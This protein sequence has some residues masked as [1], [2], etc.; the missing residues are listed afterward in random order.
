MA[1]RTF[2]SYK[3]SESTELRDRIV[4]SLGDDAGYY[5]GETSDS[6]DR[7]DQATETIK[8]NLRDMMYN[9]SVTI[10]LLSPN[11]LESKWVDWE[12]EY[13][14]KETQRKGRTSRTN[15]VVGVV[16]KVN[17]GYGWLLTTEGKP[18]GCLVNRYD[19]SYLYDIININRFNRKLKQPVCSRC[20]S[21]AELKD[22]FISFV[23]EDDFL[24]DPSSYIDN[25]FDKS[26][27]AENFDLVKMR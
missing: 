22:C 13:C 21:Y 2:I 15:G 24:L 1:H 19:E 5:Q 14:L 11:L 20:G 17:G 16:S 7:S 3:F 9:T 23:L 26:E 25:A 6:P 8:Q 10:V 18:D 12:I 4:Y 27:N